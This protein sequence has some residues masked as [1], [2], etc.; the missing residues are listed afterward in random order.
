MIKYDFDIP[1]LSYPHTRKLNLL[2]NY[3][4]IVLIENFSFCLKISSLYRKN[5]KI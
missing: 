5:Q 4:K 2:I 1:M 3:D